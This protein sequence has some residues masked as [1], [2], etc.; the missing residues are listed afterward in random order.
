VNDGTKPAS[1]KDEIKL[2][3]TEIPYRRTVN[4]S[5]PVWFDQTR[6]PVSKRWIRTPHFGTPICIDGKYTA[7]YLARK[8]D[9]N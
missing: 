6:D 8:K 5:K 1:T 7:E 2:T 3:K 9:L 4:P